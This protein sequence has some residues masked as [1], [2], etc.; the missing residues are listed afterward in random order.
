[1]V[2]RGLISILLVLLCVVCV[3]PAMAGE[4]GK[5]RAGGDRP[6]VRTE[7]GV[8]VGGSYT[9]F[10]PNSALVTVTPRFGI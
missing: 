6:R 8:G 3:V 10:K 7:W 9:F 1:M 5:G 4:K 2:K